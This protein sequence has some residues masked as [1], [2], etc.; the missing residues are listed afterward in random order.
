M[1]TNWGIKS[2]TTIVSIAGFRSSFN[3]IS[4]ISPLGVSELG[5]LAAT[6]KYG[7]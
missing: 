7:G 3:M 5:S 4:A 1:E 6:A 2:E